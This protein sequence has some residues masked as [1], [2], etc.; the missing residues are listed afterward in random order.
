[1]SAAALGGALAVCAVGGC[2]YVRTTSSRRGAGAA[3]RDRHTHTHARQCL[4]SAAVLQAMAWLASSRA[5]HAASQ[6]RAPDAQADAPAVAAPA[7]AAD[8]GG[9]R[10][11][12]AA[13]ATEAAVTDQQQADIDST[14]AQVLGLHGPISAEL[15]EEIDALYAEV[16]RQRQRAALARTALRARGL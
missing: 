3:V 16:R 2:L 15:L 4:G 8:E 11:E 12:S 5:R 9:E 1:M 13:G 7:A 6:A 14:R 10:A